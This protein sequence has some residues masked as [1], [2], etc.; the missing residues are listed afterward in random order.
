MQAWRIA[1]LCRHGELPGAH[2]ALPCVY[3]KYVGL[4]KATAV[5]TLHYRSSIGGPQKLAALI[6]TTCRFVHSV[7]NSYMCSL[8]SERKLRATV[9]SVSTSPLTPPPVL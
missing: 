8:V 6:R 5:D 4:F 7:Q 1:V 9:L 3:K 2:N